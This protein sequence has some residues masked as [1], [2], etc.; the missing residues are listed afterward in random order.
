MKKLK[1]FDRVMSI[2]LLVLLIACSVGLFLF[3]WGFLTIFMSSSLVE[4][5]QLSNAWRFNINS[6]AIVFS[7]LLTILA[8]FF[9]FVAIR[10]LFVR[11]RAP[12]QKDMGNMQSGVMLRNGEHGAAYITKDAIQYLV[13]KQVHSEHAIRDA[14]SQIDITPEQN[15]SIKLKI[16]VMADQNLPEITGKLQESLKEYIQT[17]TGIAVEAVEILVAAPPS[18]KDHSS[19]N[20][21][22]KNS[23]KMTFEA[24]AK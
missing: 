18:A 19:K 9:V 12:Q 4:G 5:V 16:S 11:Q 14:Q 3:A 22:N 2:I 21:S 15:V 13:D 17:T 24:V 6:S 1:T 7:I 10:I 23:S 20:S 8:A